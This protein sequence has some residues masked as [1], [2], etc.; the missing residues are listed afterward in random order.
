MAMNI[1]NPDAQ[2]MAHELADLTGESLTA[3]VTEALRERLARV[4]D[5]RNEGMAQRLLAIGRDVAPRLSEPYRSADHGR[6]LYN[7]RGLPA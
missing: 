5:R 3:A 2:R 6:L 7:E 1:K 4:R